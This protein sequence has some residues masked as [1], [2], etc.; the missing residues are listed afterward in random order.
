MTVRRPQVGD[1][2]E[3]TL[4]DYDDGRRI[5]ILR[6]LPPD[7]PRPSGVEAEVVSY[8]GWPTKRGSRVLLAID[9]LLKLYVFISA[10]G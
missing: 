7:S 1:V 10:E 8:P 4:V 2:F 5:K 3:S 9:D 6:T